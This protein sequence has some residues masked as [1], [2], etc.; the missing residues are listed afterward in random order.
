VLS[1]EE[2]LEYFDQVYEAF[3]DYLTNMKV[4]A[5]EESPIGWPGKTGAPT[6]ENVYVVIMMFLLDNREHLG[7]IKCIKAMWY[8][9]CEK[10]SLQS[11]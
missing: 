7:E 8:R 3:S 11:A 6:P 1:A 5:L 9:T 2:L 4:E 10:S